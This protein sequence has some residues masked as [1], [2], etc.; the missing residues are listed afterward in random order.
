MKFFRHAR[1]PPFSPSPTVGNVCQGLTGGPG[2][3]A[4]SNYSCNLQASNHS[5]GVFETA[6]R[7]SAKFLENRDKANPTSILMAGVKFLE[8]NGMQEKADLLRESLYEV[9]SGLD[10]DEIGTAEHVEKIHEK[11]IEKQGC[12]ELEQKWEFE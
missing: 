3:T 6:T 4:G 11:I 9:V 1:L 5:V 7:G 8:F 10:G 2:Y 12:F